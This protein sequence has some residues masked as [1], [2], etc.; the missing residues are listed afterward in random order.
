M[1]CILKYNYNQF[2]MLCSIPEV[3]CDNIFNYLS[4][5]D[6]RFVFGVCKTL[7]HRAY[8]ELKKRNG[9]KEPRLMYTKKTLYMSLDLLREY[10]NVVSMNRKRTKWHEELCAYGN[11]ETF[12]YIMGGSDMINDRYY[13]MSCKY[14]YLELLKYLTEK[15][16][17]NDP[18]RL[19]KTAGC[20]GHVHITKWICDKFNLMGLWLNNMV[21]EAC[22]YGHTEILK[23]VFDNHRSIYHPG[24]CMMHACEK[25]HLE[26]VKI[27]ARQGDGYV[28]DGFQKAFLNNH[29]HV[30][31][32]LCTHEQCKVSQD[33]LNTLSV[34][35]D[36]PTLKD[37]LAVYQ[38]PDTRKMFHLACEYGCA[39]VLNLLISNYA[40]TMDD[41]RE[42]LQLTN[43]HSSVVK[44]LQAK[45]GFKA[46]E[47]KTALKKSFEN[48]DLGLAKWLYHRCDISTEDVK[49]LGV[50]RSACEHGNLDMVKW[51][52]ESFNLT[53]DDAPLEECTYE[54]VAMWFCETFDTSNVDNNLIR[55]ANI[56][57]H[58]RKNRYI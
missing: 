28:G 24:V 58:Y 32:F 35:N 39:K 22:K 44:I 33:M 53:V 27:L 17:H 43:G 16:Q 8:Y 34:I 19:I 26:I 40:Y 49:D 20:H 57:L 12:K 42:G 31:R 2:E 30:V 41:V 7:N 10:P 11:V 52:Y 47:V 50:L 29:M 15:R 3:I 51:L 55:N 6:L 54:H 18:I 13:D 56:Y 4:D 36:V 1:L 25:G 21:L 9:G 46:E 14:G 48:Q 45:F 37:L 23:W 5:D 38:K